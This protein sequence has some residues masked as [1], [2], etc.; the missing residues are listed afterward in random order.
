M[1]WDRPVGLPGPAGRL[2]TPE[3]HRPVG[4]PGRTAVRGERLLPVR[5]R[6]RHRRPGE[7]HLDRP[8]GERVVGEEG[9]DAIAKAPRTGGSS[10][11]SGARVSRYQID[12]CPVAGS[13]VRRVT[14]RIVWPSKAKT[15]SSTLP[16]PASSG[17]ATEVPSNSIHSRLPAS[18][19]FS[20][21]WRT[22]QRP[23]KKSKSRAPVLRPCSRRPRAWR[24]RR[25][26][27]ERRRRGRQGPRRRRGDR[28]RCHGE[29][30]HEWERGCRSEPVIR[31]HVSRGPRELRVDM[32]PLTQR[33]RRLPRL[34]S[35]RV[36][37]VIR[38][39][40]LAG[41]GVE[42]DGVD[43][44]QPLARHRL[45]ASSSRPSTSTRCWRCARQDIDAAQFLAFARRLG[46]PQPH[47]IDQFHIRT[48]RTS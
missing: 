48:I 22:C 5:R 6:R 26:R 14:P 9:T 37:E 29:P 34:I 33:G 35:A 8:A 24:R 28:T 13:K 20:R 12:H 23:K 19:S 7:A 2:G 10:G 32:P 40:P 45:R 47:V 38:F 16:K 44:A 27:A 4:F 46:P 39:H 43:L 30:P 42:A 36:P 1:I 3:V 41:F 31:C 17:W 18:R 15:L 11:P 25:R 21:R